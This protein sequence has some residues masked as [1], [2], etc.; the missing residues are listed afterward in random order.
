MSITAAKK[1]LATDGIGRHSGKPDASLRLHYYDS[2]D[3]MS[4]RFHSMD[5]TSFRGPTLTSDVHV[6]AC[7]TVSSL[8]EEFEQRKQFFDDDAGYLIEVKSREHIAPNMNP[9]GELRKLKAMFSIWKKEYKVRLRE[10]KVALQKL[11]NS[12]TDNARK[13][14]WGKRAACGM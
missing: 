10:M 11:G 6:G 8:A 2:E 9:D 5:D 4:P 1:T 13:T 7:N 12:E 3:V 14:W